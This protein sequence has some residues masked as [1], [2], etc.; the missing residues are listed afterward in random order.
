MSW[1]NALTAPETPHN[2]SKIKRDISSYVWGNIPTREIDQACFWLRGMIEDCEIKIDQLQKIKTERERVKKWREDIRS[3]SD[4]F[5]DEDT[6]H[7]DIK[8]RS[9]IVRQ[10]LG[11]T[12]SRADLIARHINLKVK[13]EKIKDRNATIKKDLKLGMSVAAISRKH[14]ISRQHVYNILNS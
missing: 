7:I 11:C 14:R 3:L 5:Y 6:D 8:T 1:R 4:Y 2:I 10:R 12:H 13:R 9:E